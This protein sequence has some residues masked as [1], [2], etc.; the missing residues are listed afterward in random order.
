LDKATFHGPM[1]PGH[2]LQMEILVRGWHDDGI[3]IEGSV[4]DGQQTIVTADR[5]L[6][7]LFPLADYYD[8]DDLRVLYSEIHH[9]CP[10]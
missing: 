10:D 6:A 4:S 3:W 1:L 2:R 7:M 5:C 8:P 9:P